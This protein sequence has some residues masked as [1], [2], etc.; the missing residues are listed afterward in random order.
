ML[1]EYKAQLEK[2]Q[3]ASSKPKGKDKK[4]N[5]K[6]KGG[7]EPKIVDEMAESKPKP[8]KKKGKGGKNKPDPADQFDPLNFKPVSIDPQ[9]DGEQPPDLS[10]YEF[11]CSACPFGSNLQ[12]EFKTHYKSE[13]HKINQ[14]RKVKE[15]PALSEDQFKEMLILSEFA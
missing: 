10:Q 2:E 5:K 11:R 8:K 1:P 13:W 9:Q 3:Q 7:P 15:M 6:S 4:K 14:Q 12:E